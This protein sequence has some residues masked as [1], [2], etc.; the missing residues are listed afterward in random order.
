MGETNAITNVLNVCTYIHKTVNW[1]TVK[2]WCDV[3]DVRQ[4]P[5]A[6]T[7][8]KLKIFSLLFR[9]YIRGDV[10]GIIQYH[11]RSCHRIIAMSSL[12]NSHIYHHRDLHVWLLSKTYFMIFMSLNIRY[13]FLGQ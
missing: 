6:Q 3:Y 10:R 5:N 13:D 2:P 4:F 11:F 8:N 12:K 9:K 7:N 1:I